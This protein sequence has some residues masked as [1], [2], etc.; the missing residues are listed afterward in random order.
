MNEEPKTSD[1]LNSAASAPQPAIPDGYD[2]YGEVPWHR[3]SGCNGFLILLNFLTAG[4][5]P[6]TLLVCIFVLTGDIYFKEKDEHG[7]LK[8][9]GWGNKIAA[10]IL[11]LINAIYLISV[12]AQ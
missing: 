2:D 4:F 8:T 7:N 5:I 1:T 12:F 9:W 6:G 11:L 3:K 10:V